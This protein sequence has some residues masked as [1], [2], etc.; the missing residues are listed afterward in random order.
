MPVDRL[1]CGESVNVSS[2]PGPAR[3][4][5]CCLVARHER[6]VRDALISSA[7]TRRR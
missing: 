1:Q 7:K 2:W 6:Q 4:A 3:A 5:V